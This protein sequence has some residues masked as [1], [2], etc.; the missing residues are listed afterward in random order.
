[1]KKIALNIADF[2]Q[3]IMHLGRWL[4]KE[5]LNVREKGYSLRQLYVLCIRWDG[6]FALINFAVTP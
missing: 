1:M 2:P 5:L 6:V 3:L 4:E